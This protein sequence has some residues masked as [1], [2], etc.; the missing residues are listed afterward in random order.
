MVCMENNLPV[1][2]RS[3]VKYDYL[4]IWMY[5]VVG[6]NWQTQAKHAIITSKFKLAKNS[7]N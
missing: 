7:H 1:I 4:S 5:F 2:V 6:F 3:N